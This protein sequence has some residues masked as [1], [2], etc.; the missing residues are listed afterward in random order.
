MTIKFI[1]ILKEKYITQNIY[2]LSCAS[3]LKWIGINYG[4]TKFRL[5]RSRGNMWS[6]YSQA[7]FLPIQ[8][9][10]FNEICIWY[11]C[12][13]V[14]QNMGKLRKLR[15]LGQLGLID[16]SLGKG[17]SYIFDLVI[18]GMIIGDLLGICV[19]IY[20]CLGDIKLSHEYPLF[21]EKNRKKI[22]ANTLNRTRGLN[23]K[24]PQTI[25]PH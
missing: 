25:N 20:M 10:I 11:I 22:T 13:A 2:L 5:V 14:K 9:I 8:L 21:G 7:F 6:I 3:I 19:T 1:E 24:T 16:W 17:D 15:K 18:L 12:T 4:E 23:Y